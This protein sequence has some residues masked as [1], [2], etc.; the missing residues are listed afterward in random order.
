MNPL[1][2]GY[3]IF[4]FICSLNIWAWTPIKY[5]VSLQIYS[6]AMVV[7]IILAYISANFVFNKLNYTSDEQ[8]V[9]Q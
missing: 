3:S 1:I 7:I 4:A 2:I 9:K 5:L 6:L 8:G